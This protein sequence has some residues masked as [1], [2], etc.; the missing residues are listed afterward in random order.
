MPPTKPLV[1]VKWLD[2]NATQ[3][4]AYLENEIPHQPATAYTVGWL[5]RDDA[6]GISLANEYFEEDETWRGMTFIPRGMILSV[7]GTKRPRKAAA[8]PPE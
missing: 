7:T 6:T 4:V 2:A 5:L 3:T 1:T 8:A